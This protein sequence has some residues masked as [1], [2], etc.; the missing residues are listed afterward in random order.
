MGC[1]YLVIT[2]HEQ[3]MDLYKKESNRFLSL[4][5]SQIPAPYTTIEA[6]GHLLYYHCPPSSHTNTTSCGKNN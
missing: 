2:I 4:D 1:R 3:E 5:K 6:S